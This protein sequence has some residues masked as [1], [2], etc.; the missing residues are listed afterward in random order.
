MNE[1]MQ[2]CIQECQDCHRV[3][4][5]T[6][7]QHCLN[8]GGAHVEANHVRAMMDCIQICQTSA[9][10]MM[11]G[12]ERHK[13]TCGACAHICEDCARSCEALDGPEMKA[14]AV[15]CRQCAESCRKMAA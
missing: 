4:L 3:C 6:L 13:L 15:Q 1:E 9:D 8:M 7:A 10:F 5:A 11:R 14:C 2:Q 12:S